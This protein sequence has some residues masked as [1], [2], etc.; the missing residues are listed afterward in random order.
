[1]KVGLFKITWHITIDTII[2]QPSTGH[3][4]M[5]ILKGKNKTEVRQLI[6]SKEQKL[7]RCLRIIN[8]HGTSNSNVNRTSNTTTHNNHGSQMLSH[9]DGVQFGGQ[10]FG[11]VT[12]IV[13]IPFYVHMCADYGTSCTIT[14]YSMVGALVVVGVMCVTVV[15]VV[16]VG[17]IVVVVVIGLSS[18]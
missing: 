14:Y 5:K 13:H 7:G 11:D 4:V 3:D 15:I 8:T 2:L 10:R 6:K 16:V 9:A 12:G 17:V 18:L 1:M